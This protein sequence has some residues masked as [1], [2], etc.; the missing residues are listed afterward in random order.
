MEQNKKVFHLSPSIEKNI[1][2]PETYVNKPCLELPFEQLEV[3]D[4]LSLSYGYFIKAYKDHYGYD[5]SSVRKIKEIYANSSQQIIDNHKESTLR[6]FFT[7]R[8]NAARLKDPNWESN[9]RQFTWKYNPETEV[10]RCWRV[11]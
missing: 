3:T 7:S 9:K 10:L 11:L 8:K 4:S 5:H 6:Q 1:P 2:L